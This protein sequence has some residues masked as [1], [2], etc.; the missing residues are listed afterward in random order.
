MKCVIQRERYRF[1]DE[2]HYSKK[3]TETFPA[4]KV[5]SYRQCP[6]LHCISIR[7]EILKNRAALKHSSNSELSK[8][9]CLKPPFKLCE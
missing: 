6:D 9:W 2:T 5:V 1:T 3:V 7:T 8:N 4:S